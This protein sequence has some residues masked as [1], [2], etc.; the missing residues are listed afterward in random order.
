MKTFLL[1]DLGEGLP[2]AEIVEWLVEEGDTLKVDQPMVSMETAKAVVEVPSPFDGVLKKKYGAAGDVIDTGAP[3]ADFDVDGDAANADDDAGAADDSAPEP[4]EE[5]ATAEPTPVQPDAGDENSEAAEQKEQAQQEAEPRADSGTVVGAMESSDNVVVER[6]STVGGIKVTPAVRAI[7]RKLK[8]DLST[9]SGTGE[10]GVITAKDVRYAAANP[11]E[12][13]KPAV[14]QES[15]PAMDTKPA[16]PKTESQPAAKPAPKPAA[17]P[18]TPANNE[19]TPLR[20]TRRTMAR[21]M[22]KAHAEIVPTSIVDDADIHAWG[23]GADI[24][25]RVIRAVC[26]ASSVEPALN[27]WYD[28]EQNARQMHSH[29]DIGMAVDT[30]DGL[31]VSALRGCQDKDA[32][33]LRADINTLRDNV[34]NRSIPPEDLKDYTIML[35]N[36]GVFAGRYA[37]PIIA[38]PCV[39]IIGLGRKR[40]EVVAHDGGIH[41]HPI[42]PLSVTFDHRSVTGGEA[43]RF[44]AAMIEDL[45]KAD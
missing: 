45:Q 26:Y 31:F 1:P 6:G 22:A 18:A 19:M 21:T 11:Q 13:S 43:S 34:Q 42:M 2:D 27:A 10:G 20:G 39:A 3:L 8:V 16:A 37:S 30:E 25:A 36:F 32:A 33:A 44:L 7:A 17:K 4:D 24:M 38:P 12:V 40:D 14:Q 5:Q 29:V 23:D 35:S 15:Q 28:G 41:V 9:V